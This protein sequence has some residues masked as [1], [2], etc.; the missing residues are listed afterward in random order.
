MYGKYQYR[1]RCCPVDPHG[2]MV[3]PPLTWLISWEPNHNNRW[4][5]FPHIVVF[6]PLLCNSCF[7]FSKPDELYL[8]LK[9]SM[10]LRVFTLSVLVRCYRF[11]DSVLLTFFSRYVLFQAPKVFN[12]TASSGLGELGPEEPRGVILISDMGEPGVDIHYERHSY[13]GTA[14]RSGDG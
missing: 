4:L 5:A 10:W 14:A 9:F 8:S 12:P 13:G 7:L 11:C 2:H 3:Q 6:F 1:R